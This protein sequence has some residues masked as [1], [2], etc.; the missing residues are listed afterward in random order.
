MPTAVTPGPAT[1]DLAVD[2]PHSMDADAVAVA[3]DT[4]PAGLTSGAAA[5]RLAAVGPNELPAVAPTPAILRFLRHFDDTLI[6]VLLV[7]AL[8]KAIMADWLDFSVILAVTVINAAVGYA[9]EGRAEKA[10]ADIR[11]MLSN[12]ASVYRDGAWSTIPASGLVPG[13]VVRLMPGDKV[14]ADLRLLQAHELRI[15]ESALTGESVPASKGTRAVPAASGVGDRA[16]MAFSGTIVAAGQARGIV[17]GTGP[18]T[19]IG[20]IQG[21]V[22]EAGSL[23]TPLTRQLDQFGRLLTLVILGMA[24]VMLAIGHFLHR[25]P[26]ADLISA[27]IGFAVAAIPEGLPALVTITLAIGVQQ[28]ARHNAITRKLPSVETL[29]SVTTVCS[30]KTGTLTQNEMTVRRIVTADAGYTITGLGYSPRGAIVRDG[31]GAPVEGTEQAGTDRQLTALLTVG[32]LC[33]DAHIATDGDRWHLVGEPTEG[34]LRVAALKAGLTEDGRRLAV[35]PF[36]SAHKLMAVLHE[37]PDG[38]RTIVVKGAPDRLL[39]RSLTQLGAAGP[40]PLESSRWHAAIN[41]LSSQGLRVLAAARRPALHQTT[42]VTLDD[43]HDLEF[44]GLWGIA[45]PPRPEAVA[46]IAD[47]HTAGVRVKMITGDHKGTAVAIS[48]ELDLVGGGGTAAVLTGTELE[49]L[50]QRQLED[51]VAGVDVFARTSPEHKI[52]IVRALQAHGEVVAMTGDGVNDA[53]AVTRADVG[54]AMGVKGTEATRDAADIVLADDDFATIRS[55]IRE[56]RRI[57]D[58]L[59]KS[60]V[61]LLPTNG[62]QSLVVLVA[63][64]FGLVLPLTPVQVLWVNMITAVCLSLALAYEPAEPDVMRRPPRTPGGP[65]IARGELGFVLI[66]SVLIGGATLL[67][68]GAALTVTADLD[69]AR[70]VAVLTLVLAQLAYLFNCRFITRSSVTPAV[71]RGNPA[72]WWSALA[73]IA[74]Q[75]VYTYAPFMHELFDSRALAPRSWILPLALA[76][77]VFVAIEAIKSVRHVPH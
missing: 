5:A 65:I 18:R 25:W 61:F 59:R 38:V 57:Y 37:A 19:E 13:D 20:A 11:G 66:V 68:F 27:A 3:L 67:A 43:L 28:M 60:V 44:L 23:T 75:L 64:A 74:V 58:N 24:A 35:L 29:G 26:L 8:I 9:Q 49:E 6:Y 76:V 51:V 7:S 36:D 31:R 48:R 32:M 47:C 62:A 50:S 69:H 72:I 54:I 39:E 42:A 77:V 56:G 1:D 63:V 17:T 4:S 2:R 45:D 30:D 70:T 15:D 52:R 55:A 10:L 40:A 34:A 16:S 12:E 33:N 71:L 53:P 21:L 14:P 46:A 41:R 22:G 73:L